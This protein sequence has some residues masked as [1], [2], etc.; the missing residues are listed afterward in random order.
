[1]L[2]MHGSREPHP[3]TCSAALMAGGQRGLH[4]LPMAALPPR[5]SAHPLP[6]PV[7]ATTPHSL[8]RSSS[9]TWSISD[10]RR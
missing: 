7:S 10:L 3:L 2:G 1:M 8:S 4:S 9:R 5:G 6:L